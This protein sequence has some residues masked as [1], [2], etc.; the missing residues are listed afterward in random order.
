[1]KMYI[2]AM[3]KRSCLSYFR[4]FLGPFPEFVGQERRQEAKIFTSKRVAK[5]V[6]QSLGG[7]GLRIEPL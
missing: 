6:L 1:M 5:R 4:G 3:E 7:S 2:I